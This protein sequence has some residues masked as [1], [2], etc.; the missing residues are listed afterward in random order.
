MTGAKNSGK[1]AAMKQLLA[2]TLLVGLAGCAAG[3]APTLFCPRVAVLEQAQTLDA[4]LPGRS[5]VAAQLTQARITGVSG[6]CAL[7]KKQGQLVVTLQ[8]GFTATNG[9]ADQGAKLT[10][11]YFVSISDGDQIVSKNAYTVDLGFDGNQSVASTVSKP[12][13]VELPN[14]QESAG[15]DVLVGFQL[16]PQQLSVASGQL[17]GDSVP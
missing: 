7:R 16:T 15:I 11:P 2:L 1:G 5:D 13:T 3:P 9:P 12:V 14:Q 8:A 10:L 6:S 4:F 17:P